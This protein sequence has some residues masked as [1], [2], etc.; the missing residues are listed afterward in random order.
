MIKTL[1]PLNNS[2]Y[3]SFKPTQLKTGI[4]NLI[5]NQETD[6]IGIFLSTPLFAEGKKISRSLLLNRIFVY[7][8][9]VVGLTH[10]WLRC[11]KTNNQTN[12]QT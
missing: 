3:M 5:K 10:C 7:T 12:K 9:A 1:K 4:T 2:N 6:S 8:S 11:R